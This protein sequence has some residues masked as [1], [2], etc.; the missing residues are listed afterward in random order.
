MLASLK[1]LARTGLAVATGLALEA[2]WRRAA[3]RPTG[4][5]HG[6]DKPLVVSLTSYPPRYGTLVPTLKS[7]LMQSVK[8]DHIELWV[9]DTDFASLPADALAL[10]RVG[11]TIRTCADIR[12]FKKIIPALAAHPEAIIVTA[13]DD[14]YYW[15]T[16]LETLVAAYRG[17]ANEV[18]CHRAHEIVF[19]GDRPASY[20][21]WRFETAR[22]D[23]SRTVFPTGLGG[24]LYPPGIFASDV[25]RQGLFETYC[26]T[27]DD[28]WLFWMAALRGAHFRKVGPVR[29]FVLW[30]SGQ[31]V[32]LYSHNAGEDDANDRQI[33]AM[34][35]AYGFPAAREPA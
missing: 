8:P 31:A 16:W 1:A 25:S 35:E 7:L 18:L 29:R 2:R 11:L 9:A 12:S 19:D 4:R 30:P 21:T 3:G 26:P 10:Q 5:P 13:D 24:I 33:A 23:A 28:V 20:R 34:I 22:T 6:L 17:D 14:A 15:R 27:A 32:S